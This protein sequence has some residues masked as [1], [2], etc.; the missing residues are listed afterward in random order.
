MRNLRRS[1]RIYAA[2][3]RALWLRALE[4]RAQLAL[5]LLSS[6]FPLVMMAIWLALISEAG[7]INGWGDVEFVS[8]YVA[9]AVCRSLTEVWITWTWDEQ[10]R[11]GELSVKLLKPVDPLTQIVGYE[12][13][14]WK[15]L[16]AAILVPLVS[17]LALLS[18]L[19]N[20]TTDPLR[21]LACAAMVIAAMIMNT[22]LASVFGV[23]GLWTTQSRNLFGLLYGGVGQFFA[24]FIAPLS[25]FP[26]GFQAIA[27]VLP[28]RSSLALPVEILMGRLS[29]AEIAVGF[30]V[31][32]AW[33]I[34][35]WL[36]YRWL[37][38]RG[39][40]HYEAVGA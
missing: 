27:G 38:R 40:R 20:Y 5:W 6:I 4:Y 11:T 13:L 7:A 3:I 32:F 29:G 18:P 25:L 8:Y 19:V 14:G 10:L 26:E 34:G 9:A 16:I 30:L 36:L 31:T 33:G 35:A 22:Y 1:G 23:L 2:L 37:W 12:V 24:G 21:I 39:L 28:F 17:V 15:L